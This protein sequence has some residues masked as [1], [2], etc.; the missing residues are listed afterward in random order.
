MMSDRITRLIKSLGEWR[1][2]TALLQLM[3]YY[4][5]TNLFSITQEEAEIFYMLYDNIVAKH[6]VDYYGYPRKLK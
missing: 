2:G 6:E 1:M 5:K 4:N 3:Q